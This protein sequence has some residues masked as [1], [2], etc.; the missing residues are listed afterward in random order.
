L[1]MTDAAN[2]DQLFLGF[3]GELEDTIASIWL[4]LG[5]IHMI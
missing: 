2:G 5:Q 1:E 3:Y 4:K